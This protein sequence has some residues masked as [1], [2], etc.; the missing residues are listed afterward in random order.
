VHERV[1]RVEVGEVGRV[2]GAAEVGGELRQRL[3]RA[4]DEREVRAARREA[5][6]ERRAEATRG[7]GD[8]DAGAGD[9]QV[10]APRRL[11]ATLGPRLESPR[12][13]TLPL[14]AASCVLRAAE[15]GARPDYIGA[16]NRRR[17]GAW[18]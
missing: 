1:D 3:G 5:G 9:V 8:D 10:R 16:G 15:R 12:T 2:G 14:G 4:G 7:A 11:P 17:A 18:C 13:R 6:G